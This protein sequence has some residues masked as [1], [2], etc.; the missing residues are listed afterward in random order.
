MIFPH[1]TGNSMLCDN[2]LLC[3]RPLF[4]YPI[5]SWLGSPQPRKATKFSLFQPPG[6]HKEP[7]L[8]QNNQ[9]HLCCY[10]DNTSPRPDSISTSAAASDVPYPDFEAVPVSP[11]LYPPRGQQ[12]FTRKSLH[13]PRTCLKMNRWL[14]LTSQL[15][16]QDV[17]ASVPLTF[18][19]KSPLCTSSHSGR[20]TTVARFSFRGTV[21]LLLWAW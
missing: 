21:I 2:T 20:L 17:L 12:T 18:T 15:T 19:R 3:P 5:S 1:L 8:G 13:L 4:S 6:V 10:L 7:E 9:S 16:Y 14:S 11:Y